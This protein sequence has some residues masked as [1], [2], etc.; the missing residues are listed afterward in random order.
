MG[1]ILT[2][3]PFLVKIISVQVE[4]VSINKKD[5]LVL[6]I[7]QATIGQMESVPILMN[8]HYQL[9]IA[10][11]VIV[12]ILKEAIFVHVLRYFKITPYQ[13]ENG[14]RVPLSTSFNLKI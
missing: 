13:K 12:K 1:K 6:V 14:Y 4:D 7:E 5:L 10:M 11:A 8:A 3:V 9:F 2:N